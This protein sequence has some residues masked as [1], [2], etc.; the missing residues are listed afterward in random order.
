[1]TIP[2]EVYSALGPIPVTVE[3]LNDP[4]EEDCTNYGAFTPSTRT[5]KLDKNMHPAWT[6]KVFFHELAHVA[7]VD[8]GVADLLAKGDFEEMVCDALGTYFAAAVQ[9][10]YMVIRVDPPPQERQ[11]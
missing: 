1:M 11:G 8:A 7:L 3:D 6:L 5:I 2:K 4:P 10:G 9:N